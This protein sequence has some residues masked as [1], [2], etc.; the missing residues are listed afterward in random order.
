[1][2]TE[3]F[4]RSL[5]VLMRL[6]EMPDNPAAAA[7]K[8]PSVAEPCSAEATADEAPTVATLMPPLPLVAPEPPELVAWELLDVIRTEL[9]A[10]PELSDTALPPV[11]SEKF[12]GE[13]KKEGIEEK[14]HHFRMRK[15]QCDK[16][17]Y[18]IFLKN[19]HL[20]S[21]SKILSK[22]SCSGRHCPLGP[23]MAHM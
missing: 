1:M 18:C 20:L 15:L 2:V 13:Q 12:A 7:P 21:E 22:L 4:P 8:P 19:F 6:E 5:P 3:P 16:M 14:T 9:L 11:L 23:V 10:P 17:I